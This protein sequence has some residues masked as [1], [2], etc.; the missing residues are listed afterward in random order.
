MKVFQACG[1]TGIDVPTPPT[2]PIL[3]YL[4]L[5]GAVYSKLVEKA[6]DDP[7]VKSCK[8]YSQAIQIAEKSQSK[9]QGA[10]LRL[11]QCRLFLKWADDSSLGAIK[12]QVVSD[13]D[14]IIANLEGVDDELVKNAKRVRRDVIYNDRQK[15]IKDVVKA[16]NVI[17]G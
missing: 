5:I 3:E 11:K 7:Y 15:E 8:V 16:M 10:K 14:W 17:Q 4:R 13:M 12:N 6:S 2:A 9:A 1:G